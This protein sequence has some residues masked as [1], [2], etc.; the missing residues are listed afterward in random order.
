MQIGE[1][2]N[3]RQLNVI[4]KLRPMPG[5]RSLDLLFLLEFI[6]ISS[7]YDV[8]TKHFSVFHQAHQSMTGIVPSACLSNLLIYVCEHECVSTCVFVCASMCTLKAKDG[9]W[10]I[11]S[12]CSDLD[13]LT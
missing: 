5:C 9:R 2:T 4:N 6:C 11:W 7:A 8:H 1:G 10:Y 3:N 12:Q 13:L